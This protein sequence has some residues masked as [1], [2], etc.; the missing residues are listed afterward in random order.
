MIS[1]SEQQKCNKVC[2]HVI[3]LPLLVTEPSFVCNGMHV[4]ASIII[5][6]QGSG[7]SVD[8][9]PSINQDLS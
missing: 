2:V 9:A 3:S 5:S 4:L 8:R 1:C 6:T 7:W